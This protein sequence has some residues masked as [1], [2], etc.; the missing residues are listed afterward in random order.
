MET[1][2]KRASIR[3]ILLDL[4]AIFA[5]AF[6]P[7]KQWMACFFM[8]SSMVCLG[9]TTLFDADW[10]FMEDAPE[11]ATQVSFD[12]SQ[13]RSVTLPHDFIIEHDFTGKNG[14]GPFLKDIKDSIST[15]NT[16]G[17]T[18]WYRKHFKLTNRPAG[19]KV[20]IVFDGV[21]VLSDVWLNGH[22]LGFHPNGYTPF[23][24]DLTPYLK[25]ANQENILTVRAHNT[26]DNSRWY[27]GGGIY[28]H[29]YLI[30][31]GAIHFPVWGVQV[32]T[33]VTDN[34]ATIKF[35]VPLKN[36]TRRTRNIQL[37]TKVL[38]ASGKEVVGSDLSTKLSSKGDTLYTSCKVSNPHLW[39]PET[40]Y[41]YKAEVQVFNGKKLMDH[42]TTP[43]GIRTISFS[44]E[45]GFLLN[46]KSTKLHGACMHHDN[47]IL[48]VAAY[49]KAEA[50]RVS[51]MKQNGFNA[52]RTSHNRP[53]AAFLQ[54]CDSLG[55]F[56]I[57]E[58]FDSWLI[59]KRD[60][61][62]HLYFS[63]WADRDQAALVQCDRNHPSVLMWSIGNEIP[64]DQTPEGA[65]ISRRLA[66]IVKANDT[67]RPVTDGVCAFAQR[68]GLIKDQLDDV[69]AAL[70]I[71]G[72]N[73]RLREIYAD[74]LQFPNRIIVSTESF[75]RETYLNYQLEQSL[76]CY[77]GSFVW[78]GMDYIGEVGIGNAV[79][80]DNTTLNYARPTRLWP[81]YVSFCGDID[82]I[83]NK[84][85]QSYY[86]D[87]VWK[88]SQMEMAVAP[89]V[90][91]KFELVSKWGWYDELRSWN[92]KGYEN[93]PLTV[94]VYSYAD[95]VALFLNG[96]KIAQAPVLKN[97]LI[98]EFQVPFQPG[99]LTAIGYDKEGKEI[100]TQT[101]KTQTPTRIQLIAESKSITNDVNDLAYVRINIVDN[102]GNIVPE[103]ATKLHLSVSGAGKLLASGNG[104]PDDMESFRRPDCK[105]WHGS[106]LAVLQASS[107]GTM[108][109]TVSSDVFPTEKVDILVK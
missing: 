23:F 66:N 99:T 16:P 106:C 30:Q 1:V 100:A 69:Y 53:S 27:C 2:K 46:G 5:V 75:P 48:G 40:P 72:Y 63:E 93:K 17:G 6:L 86:R 9:Q 70:D 37:I 109:L 25:G 79:Y 15:G 64:G 62:Y 60:N 68:E 85:A 95:Q 81:W 90:E 31:T 55:V 19:G 33:D 101:L 51:V 4:K 59:G 87:V 12:D 29:V 76:Q 50:R 108:A 107:E 28:R 102:E 92:W 34:V 7:K 44:A 105:T 56:V 61:D 94:R 3:R 24:Y 45:Q 18:G 91:G 8:L 36:E 35:D 10:K 98:A 54:A 49:D 78:T 11:N 89:V 84:K 47:G 96:K 80:T 52:I 82:L 74:H 13:W 22:H 77:L 67:T 14:I 58:S 71:W 57:N 38:D 97:N 20:Y 32:K 103:A 42:Y 83:G 21:S 43:F 88:R 39:S 41:L 26:A 104:A 65:A 73:Y